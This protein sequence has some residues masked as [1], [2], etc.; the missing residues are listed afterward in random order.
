MNQLKSVFLIS[1]AIVI[2]SKTPRG[3]YNPTLHL[4]TVSKSDQI[5]LVL[6]EGSAPTHSKTFE[7][8]ADDDP[9]PGQDR[10]Y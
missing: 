4:N 3:Y 7:Y 8:P 5:P 10:C 9:D 1:K 2:K 6:S